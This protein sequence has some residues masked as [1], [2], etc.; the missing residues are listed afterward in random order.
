MLNGHASKYSAYHTYQTRMPSLCSDAHDGSSKHMSWC[1]L[2]HGRGLMIGQM[3]KG[4]RQGRGADE[5]DQLEPAMHGLPHIGS[6][7]AGQ[8]QRFMRP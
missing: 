3:V 7:G 2:S 4:S 8:E 6:A 1:W 5:V